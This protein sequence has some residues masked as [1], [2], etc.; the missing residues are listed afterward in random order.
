MSLAEIKSEI[1]ALS[2]EEKEELRRFLI[3]EKTRND[4]EWAKEMDRRIEDV[5]AGNYYT[6]E[7]LQRIYAARPAG[8]K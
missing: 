3:I 4:P 1:A 7:D 2:A 5:R 6:K 8:G